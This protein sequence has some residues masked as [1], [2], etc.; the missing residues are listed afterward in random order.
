M[1]AFFRTGARLLAATLVLTLLPGPTGAQEPAAAAAS[2]HPWKAAYAKRMAEGRMRRQQASEKRKAQLKTRARQ[3]RSASGADAPRRGLRAR[4]VLPEANPAIANDVTV[5]RRT[6]RFGAQAFAT[7][8]NRIV[9]DR[10]GDNGASGQCET[11]IAAFGDILVAAWND[12]Q[13]F[14]TNSDTQGWAFSTDG[15]STWSDRG[16][17][18]ST[19]P[20]TS[21]FEWTSD[22]VVTVNEK[23]GAFYFSALCDFTTGLG[24][25]SGVG[26]VKGRW[27]GADFVWGT[28]TIAR[29]L[30]YLEPDKEW[31]VA[32]SASGRVFL[33]YTRFPI[34]G[35]VIDFQWADSNATTWS[36]PRQIS[37]DTSLER[38]YVQGSRPA[39]DGDG[40]V[41]VVYE[42]I[43]DSFEDYFRIRRSDDRGQTFALPVTAVSMYTNF[44]T[45]GPGFNRD[46]GVEFSGIAVDRSHGPQRGRI[47]LSWA[48]S[49]NWLDEVL[50]L[51][52]AGNKSEVESNGTPGSATPVTPGQTIRGA[53]SGTLDVDYYALPL[54]QG[55]HVVVAADSAE[56]SAVLDLRLLAGD[57]LTRL[58]FTTFNSSVNPSVGNP[59]G[60][61]S[62][63]LFTAPV[64]GTYYLHVEF[65]SGAGSGAYR[66]RTGS[67]NRGL[68][69]G[70]DQRDIF[71]GW[72]DDATTWSAPNRLS[73]DPVG[74]DSWLP[75]VAVAPDGG[76]YCAWHDYR[77]AAPSKNG[78]EAG[79]YLSR[80]PDGGLTWTT[81]GALA[82]TLTDWSNSVTNIMPNQG[83]YLSLI[84]T[85]S[86]VVTCWSDA[87]RGNPD[88]FAARV[89]LIPN[90]AQVAVRNV[91]RENRRISIDWETSPADTLTMRLYRSTDGG[92]F[93]YRDLVYFDTGGRLTYTDTTVTGDH[94]YSYRL[95]R[96]I[97]GVEIYYGQVSVF[98][99]S[100][101]PLSLGLPR[102]QPVVGS[103]FGVILSLAT[104]EAA[105]LIL[106]DISGRE[107]FRQR[108]N[109]GRGPH[110]LT[111]PVGPGLSQGLYILTLRQ[112]G[113]NTST[114]V[115]LLR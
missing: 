46:H 103:T 73:E 8:V 110:T 26:V 47:Y 55:Q 56:A 48:E 13:G 33:S 89:P 60:F 59:Q 51:G 84:A 43:G 86:Q 93:Q 7:P 74:F 81:L 114:R 63:W 25:R 27:N 75:E 71:V 32:D 97:T 38:G 77:D 99:P 36:T 82:D 17:F 40:R 91:R 68:E 28:P 49:I 58:T 67:V 96:F 15:G 69:R 12:G 88:V 83:D 41:F 106:H 1:I 54:A 9:N 39:V 53:V 66:L 10:S 29:N 113:R 61:P 90:G 42:L 11:S 105:D 35:S 70:R 24:L 100:S 18:P 87:R 6:A 20:G 2:V 72:S 115:H 3:Q 30:P 64:T 50:T 37:L 94:G 62:A 112:G 76:V 16:T 34:T 65:R 45:G 104:D 14:V 22:P 31:V 102:P 21:A 111:L 98:L 5:V 101:F 23:T 95:G 57:A 44:G 85:Q 107:V 52:L 4:P 79:V 92:A 19:V 78:G 108:V 80:S 109:L